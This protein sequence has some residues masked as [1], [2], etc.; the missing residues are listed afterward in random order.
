MNHLFDLLIESTNL[1][2]SA[3][4]VKYK[5]AKAIGIDGINSN[6][7]E[8]YLESHIEEL[9]QSLKDET[10][11]PQPI[12]QIAIDK[13]NGGKRLIGIPTVQDKIIQLAIVQVLSPIYEKK[14]STYSYGF[15]EKRNIHQAII[16]AMQFMNDGYIWVAALDLSKYFDTIHHDRLMSVL[17]QDI[18]DRK[19]LRLIRQF[20]QSDVVYRNSKVQKELNRGAIQGGN[21]SPLLANIYLDKLD[22]ELSRRGI[23]FIRY[24]DDI[25]LFLR[26]K[27]SAEKICQNISKFIEDKLLLKVNQKKTMIA[28][29]SGINL[30]GFQFY[31]D[32]QEYKSCIPDKS[33]QR[34]KEKILNKIDKTETLDRAV[35]QVNEEITGWTSHYIHADRPLSQRQAKDIDRMILERLYKRFKTNT[36]I[37]QFKEQLFMISKG[38]VSL[39][40]MH[41]LWKKRMIK[42]TKANVKVN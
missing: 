7:A 5:A 34:M 10:F 4:I 17:F 21:L 33:I 14:F 12:R 9:I 13:P 29:P 41:R 15:R 24:A 6:D 27:K 18:K 25:T 42:S 11:R 20:L 1:Y 30:L 31:I 23:R 8:R 39:V 28:T 32:K 37:G 35:K 26:D 40:S 22:R 38:K 36:D 19:L 3:R 2:Q 16:Q